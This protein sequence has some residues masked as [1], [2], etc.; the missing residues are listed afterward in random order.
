M[1]ESTQSL[2]YTVKAYCR[3]IR[4]TCYKD[5][6]ENVKRVA[7]SVINYYYLHDFISHDMYYHLRSMILA[8]MIEGGFKG[9]DR[10]FSFGCHA[11]KAYKPIFK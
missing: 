7:K 3:L 5:I 10:S 1:R 9:T 8:S 2:Y 6:A 11:S 4:K